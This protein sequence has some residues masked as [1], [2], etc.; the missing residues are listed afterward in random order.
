LLTVYSMTKIW[1]EP[2][3]KPKAAATPPPAD[4]LSRVSAWMLA[5]VAALAAL[6]VLIGLA[7]EQL[8]QMARLAA[9]ELLDPSAYVH[10]VLGSVR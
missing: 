6:T 1:N 2:F 4:G 3:W 10:S 8:F 7:P 5:P 9:E